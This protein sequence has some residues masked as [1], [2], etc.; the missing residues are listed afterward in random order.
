MNLI[1]E[2]TNQENLQNKIVNHGIASRDSPLKSIT[3]FFLTGSLSK[4]SKRNLKMSKNKRCVSTAN[5][6]G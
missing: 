5:N 1:Y 6:E 4:N 2:D 3:D